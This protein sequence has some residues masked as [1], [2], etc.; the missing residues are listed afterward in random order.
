MKSRAEKILVPA[1]FARAFEIP[2]GGEFDIIDVAGGQIAD[3]VAFSFK[4]P[5]ES[6]SAP[7]TRLG[8]HSIRIGKGS[9]LYSNRRRPMLEVTEDS[10]G[11]HDL[12]IPA[13]DE[14]RYS[15][16]YGVTEHRNCVD[17][18]TEALAPWGIRKRDIPDPLNIFENSG[19]GDDG[20]L[21]HFPVV[22]KA[23]D[24]IRFRAL[25]ALVCAV[26]ACPMDLN[27]T[28]GDAITDI[29]VR[30]LPSSRED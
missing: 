27:V 4:D 20:E 1:G 6:F 5:L 26:S 14:Y 2:A 29:L 12:L 24:Y 28:G 25:M 23:G 8:N 18:F 13:C 11:T 21:L 9:A 15:V 19:I 17:N 7:C 30:F 3:F 10:V 22:S 16:D